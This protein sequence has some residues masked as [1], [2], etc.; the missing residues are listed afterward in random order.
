MT[1]LVS[2]WTL[3]SISSLFVAAQGKNELVLTENTSKAIVR[4]ALRNSH[5]IFLKGPSE[6]YD[7]VING[8]E[9]LLFKVYG[10]KRILNEKPYHCSSDEIWWHLYGDLPTGSLGGVFEVIIGKETKE[11]MKIIHTQ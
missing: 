9:V 5:R 10:R 11:V 4:K 6:N 3:L 2:M 7:Q 8:A 1:T